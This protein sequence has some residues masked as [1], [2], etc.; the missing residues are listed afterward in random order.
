MKWKTTKRG[1]FPR[2]DMMAADFRCLCCG[3]VQ[4]FEA[5]QSKQIC[6]RCG[7]Y[8]SN[9]DLKKIFSRYKTTETERQKTTEQLT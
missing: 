4:P 2:W 7:G 3:S 5:E 8:F 6:R 1:W 9:S